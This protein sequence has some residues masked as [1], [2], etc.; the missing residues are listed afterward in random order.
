MDSFPFCDPLKR[1][2]YP[3][4]EIKRYLKLCDW[5]EFLLVHSQNLNFFFYISP[6]AFSCSKGWGDKGY[7]YLFIFFSTPRSF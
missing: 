5:W 6:P 1:N 2:I 4:E 3:S 7:I